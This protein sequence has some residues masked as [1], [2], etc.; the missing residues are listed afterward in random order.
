[1]QRHYWIPVR[2]VAKGF[3]RIEAVSAEAALEILESG[4]WQED[5]LI[6]MDIDSVECI[7]APHEETTA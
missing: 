4:A 5:E 3:L 6:D 7:G 2:T 1:M